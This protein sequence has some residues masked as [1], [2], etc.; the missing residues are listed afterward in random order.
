MLISG[1]Y[2]DFNT[3]KPVVALE[4]GFHLRLQETRKEVARNFYG[5]QNYRSHYLGKVVKEPHL[6]ESYWEYF[7]LL[8]DRDL[9]TGDVL[10]DLVRHECSI[11][12]PLA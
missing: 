9:M 11:A 5:S 6:R 1:N 10:Q 2:R 7:Q 4:G 12:A 3:E 8:N